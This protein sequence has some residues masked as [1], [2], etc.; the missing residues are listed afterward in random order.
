VEYFHDHVRIDQM[1]FDGIVEPRDGM[2]RP[3]PSRLGHGIELKLA[4]AEKYRV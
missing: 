3:D 1:I 2:L 4:D